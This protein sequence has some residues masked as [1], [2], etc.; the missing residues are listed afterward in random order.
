[1]KALLI[2]LIYFFDPEIMRS[3]AFIIIVRILSYENFDILQKTQVNIFILEHNI[4]EKHFAFFY[5][6]TTS[7]ILQ[8]SNYDRPNVESK[9]KFF[10]ENHHL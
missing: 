9:D 2:Y 10:P 3:L 5:N 1:M 7:V 6:S 8:R 4:N